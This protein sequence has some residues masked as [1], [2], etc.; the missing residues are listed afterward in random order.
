MAQGT[1]AFTMTTLERKR[2]EKFRRKDKDARVY[3]RLSALLWLADGRPAEAVA[4]LLGV[5]P[6]TVNNWLA[7]YRAGGLDLLRRLDYQGDPG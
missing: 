7:L 1:S 4:A 5:C 6:R 2:V 3:A